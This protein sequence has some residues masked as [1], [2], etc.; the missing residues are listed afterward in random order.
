MKL[1][2]NHQTHYSY[3]ETARNSIQYIKMMP[4]TSPHQHVMNWA[5]SVPGDK[6]I[7]R[8]IFNNVWMTASQRYPYQH[9]TFMAQG[10]VELQNIELGC[11]DLSTPTN[12]FLQMTGATRCDTEMLDFAKNIV[13]NKD[14]QHIALLSENILQ[15]ILY[16]PESTSVQTTAIEAFQAG[17]GV[18]QDH[19][20][21][22]IAMCRA[23]QLPARYVSGYLFDQ[24]YP[25]LASHAWVEVFL[26]NQWYC[27]DVSNQ[28]FTPKH[29]IYLAV[30]RDYLDVAP[31]RGV[32]EQGGVEN[33]MSVVQVLAC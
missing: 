23:L 28:L 31:I 5:I 29:H 17:Q 30:G 14:R 16:Q 6:T 26:E 13:V 20:H 3:T 4:Q 11:V 24:N 19:A 18:C 33:M 25:H 7:K 21:I 27:F 9:L 1:M 10:I 8:D 15:K 2:V 32:R 22:L 12:L